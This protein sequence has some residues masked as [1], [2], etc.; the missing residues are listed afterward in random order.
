MN[1]AVE[2]ADP[3]IAQIYNILPFEKYLQAMAK[4][5][6]HHTQRLLFI[7]KSKH[8]LFWSIKKY[9]NYTEGL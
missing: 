3:E 5:Y 4:S 1:P 6:N 2:P 7:T 8:I 9:I